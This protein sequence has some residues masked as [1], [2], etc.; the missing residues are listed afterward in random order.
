MYGKDDAFIQVEFCYQHAVEGR[1]LVLL[2]V[3]NGVTTVPVWSEMDAS[4]T[5]RSLPVFSKSNT[6]KLSS[7]LSRS[8]G[9]S[10][11]PMLDVVLLDCELLAVFSEDCL[12]IGDNFCVDEFCL[13]NMIRDGMDMFIMASEAKARMDGCLDIIPDDRCLD[14]M[15]GFSGEETMDLHDGDMLLLFDIC[16]RHKEPSESSRLIDRRG[17]V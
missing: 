5:S 10:P 6:F 2:P 11:T 12:L 8:C 9:S 14:I 13:D 15:G 4:S 17:D 16:G 3:A 7:E 1:R